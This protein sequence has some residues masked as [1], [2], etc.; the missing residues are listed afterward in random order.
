MTFINQLNLNTQLRFHRL[1]GCVLVSVVGLTAC[2]QPINQS[3]LSTQALQSETELSETDSPDAELSQ[4]EI[5]PSESP[6]P[7]S[8]ATASPVQRRVQVFF[9]VAASQAPTVVRPVWRTTSSPGVAQY[10]I[11]QLIAGPTSSEKQQGLAAIPRPSGSS[12]CGQDF[13]ISINDG[14]AELRFCKKMIHGG[15][16]D[17][18]RTRSALEATLKQFSTVSYVRILDQ[19]GNCL[20]DE[21]G[22]NIC[23]GKGSNP[24][25]LTS[26]SQVAINGFGPVMLG[27]T[28]SEASQAAG[29]DLVPLS[30]NPNPVCASYQPAKTPE[31]LGATTFMV[32]NGRIARIDIG[33]SRPKTVSGARVGDTENQVKSL[34]SGRLQVNS[35]PNSAQGHF[36]T[37]VP[38]SQRD[39][40]LRLK[41]ATDGNKVTEIIIGQLPEVNYIEG[42]LD[43]VP[44][45]I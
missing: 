31:G 21:S 44:G 38:T 32:R 36:L 13:T 30:S 4:A 15:I 40:N 14:V 24:E 28:V 9:P 8:G 33:D 23:L 43:I 45:G 42:C 18:A 27:M 20:G 1:V 25:K 34:Y 7:T 35:L 29:I 41:F 11:A 19:N 37:F 10:A 12:N 22:E 3:K 39:R 6:A 16:L 26:L 17:S 5:S 2:G